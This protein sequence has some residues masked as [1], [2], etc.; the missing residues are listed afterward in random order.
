VTEADVMREQGVS[1]I[2]FSMAA[3]AATLTGS[4]EAR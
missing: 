3:Q 2:R 1:R 4:D